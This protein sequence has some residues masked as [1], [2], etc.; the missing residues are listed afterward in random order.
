MPEKSIDA[1]LLRKIESRLSIVETNYERL[2]DDVHTT[3]DSLER[4]AER[5]S[6]AI[7]SIVT[8][9]ASAK[10]PQWGA[11]AS[12]AGVILTV[13]GLLLAGYSRDQARLETQV[14]DH[15]ST[16]E[17]Q[18]NDCMDDFMKIHDQIR[19]IE[20]ALAE[21]KTKQSIMY[22]AMIPGIVDRLQELE[23]VARSK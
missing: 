20:A 22:D 1:E 2:I 21:V 15:A 19:I 10:V 7:E 3:A 9:L 14:A 5:T 11:L 8:K 23:H 12:W 18:N 13:V 16:A 17:R 4:H 6:S